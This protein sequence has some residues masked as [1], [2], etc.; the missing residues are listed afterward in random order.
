M[1]IHECLFAL[2]ASPSMDFG[3]AELRLLRPPT[4]QVFIP[5]A[6]CLRFFYP[7]TQGGTTGGSDKLQL[8]GEL[9]LQSR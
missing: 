1:E 2:K 3:L 7:R 9:V 6:L 8:S 4:G 5:F